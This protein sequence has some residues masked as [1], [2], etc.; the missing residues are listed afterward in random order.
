MRVRAFPC[1]VL[2]LGLALAGCGS[3]DDPVVAGS[4]PEAGK[5]KTYVLA[6]GD[7]IKVPAPP[8]GDAAR[9]E[10]EE[11]QRLAGQRSP[12]VEEKVKHW[13]QEPAL[14]PWLALN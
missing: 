5:W 9:A 2:A 10:Q 3:D 1:A 11:L 8:T 12:Q 6:S 14:Q 13:N 7:D 4:E